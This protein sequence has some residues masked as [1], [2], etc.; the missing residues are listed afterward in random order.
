MMS[1]EQGESAQTQYHD[2][3]DVLPSD[4]KV[5]AMPPVGQKADEIETVHGDRAVRRLLTASLVCFAIP[6][7]VWIVTVIWLMYLGALLRGKDL[8][9]A[10]G[11]VL[12]GLAATPL[13][14]GAMGT[15]F[16]GGSLVMLLGLHQIC[17]CSRR[18]IRAH[19]WGGRA[20]VVCAV[21]ASVGGLVFIGSKRTLVGGRARFFPISRSV[22]TANAE[23]PFRPEG[24]RRRVSPRPLRRHPL[25]QSSPR[26]APEKWLK[27]DPRSGPAMTASFAIYG[28]L[29]LATSLS[30]AWTA[31]RQQMAAHR[32][33]ASHA[34][35][36]VP[37]L[38]NIRSPSC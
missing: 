33:L 29:L 19:R 5:T 7:V 12:P 21:L 35:G 14:A 15:H 2:L 31:R 38:L 10:W 32:R 17:P 27:I 13:E 16:L 11:D 34:F 3:G 26:H 18:R 25:I 28:V 4:T 8:A 22:P 6:A 37:Q 30:A 1:Q 23:D 36:Q 9:D 24:A 20:F